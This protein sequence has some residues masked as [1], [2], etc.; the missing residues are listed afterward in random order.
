M[1]AINEKPEI[2][3]LN[4]MLLKE[5]YENDTLNAALMDAESKMEKGKLTSFQAAEQLFE[6][7]KKNGKV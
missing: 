6:I 1:K 4:E 2:E 7:Y 3:T 5:F